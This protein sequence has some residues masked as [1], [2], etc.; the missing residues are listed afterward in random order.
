MATGVVLTYLAIAAVA[1]PILWI[2]W[3]GAGSIGRNGRARLVPAPVAAGQALAPAGMDR[4]Y[5][6]DVALEGTRG[7]VTLYNARGVQV[8]TC[9]GPDSAGRCPRPLAD[10]SVPC[11]GCLLAL[12][13]AVQGSRQW[14]IPEGYRACMLGSYGAYRQAGP[15]A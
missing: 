1:A 12:P 10:G 11:A 4:P 6:A 13:A 5:P 14:H 8:E 2:M 15:T 9:H 3:W 7:R